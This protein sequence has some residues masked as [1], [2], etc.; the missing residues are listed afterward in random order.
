MQVNAS[1]KVFD[2]YYEQSEIFY[3]TFSFLFEIFD[4]LNA[5]IYNFV[6]S[7]TVIWDKNEIHIIECVLALAL[8]M[9]SFYASVI[10]KWIDYRLQHIIYW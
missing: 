7:I 4:A 9:K 1:P 5:P 6:S 10:I 3:I 2:L 8:V